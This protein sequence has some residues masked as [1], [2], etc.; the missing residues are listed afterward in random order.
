MSD[1]GTEILADVEKTF[2]R[3]LLTD[4]KLKKLANRVRDGTDY[5]VA[6][7]YA[8]R[9][10]ELLSEALN[11]STKT[12]SFISSEVADEVLRPLL[13]NQHDIVAEVTNQIQANFNQAQNIGLAVQTPA[14]DTNRIAGFVEKVSSYQTMDEARWMLKEPIINYSQAIVDQ[15]VRDNAKVISKTTNRN[16]YIIRKAEASGVRTIKRGNRTV[17]YTVP[18]KWCQNLEG[19]YRYGD[20][21][22][23]VYRRHEACRCTVT[24]VT[25]AKKQDVWTKKEW[26]NEDADEQ[27]DAVKEAAEQASGNDPKSIAGAPKGKRMT[28]DEADNGNVNPNFYQSHGYQINCQSC[29]VTM[30]ARLRGYDV[31]VLPRTKGSMLEKLSYNTSLAWKNKDGSMA[32]Y[33]IGSDKEFWKRHSSRDY[34]NPKKLETLLKEKLVPEGRYNIGF[35]W[36]GRSRSGHIIDIDISEDNVLHIYD[37][38][39]N[40][41][42]YGS[43]VLDYFK[44]LKYT[45]TFRGEK[46]P[47][48]IQVM[49]VD[50]KDFN[51]E[52]VDKIMRAK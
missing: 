27:I 5:A 51:M 44:D 11:D 29:V 48:S 13:T 17:K 50:D 30:E 22:E 26:T 19:K 40:T 49:R 8:V 38:Q 3:K 4:K 47:S 7:D 6:N 24:F 23:D 18:C 20:E 10:G 42:Y 15:S 39:V 46:Y 36:K 1:L 16:A 32:E 41:N 21:P 34:L 43:E 28:F 31:E 37:P 52:V 9:A 45:Q 25:E 12:L 35:A 2:A 33:L 14:L